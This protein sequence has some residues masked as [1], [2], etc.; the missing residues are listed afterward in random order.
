MT[1]A[2]C[3]KSKPQQSDEM[4]IVTSFYP[5]YIMT[6]NVAG[7]I[8]GIRVENLTPPLTGCLHDYSLT[9]DEM[10]KLE[11]ASVFVTNGAGM[12]SFTYSV[13]RRDPKLKIIDCSAGIYLITENGTENPHVW[14]SVSGAIAEVTNLRNALVKIDPAHAEQYKKNAEQYIM[15]LEELRTQMKSA[16][17]PYRG[18]KIITFHEAFPYFAREFNL[19]IAAVVERDPGSEPSARELAETIALVRGSGIKTIFTEPQYSTAAAKV[20]A[21]ETGAR[22]FTLDPAVSG[23]DDPDAYLITMKK[24]LSTLKEALQ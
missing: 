12:E 6:L 13:A 18:Q 5:I 9:T 20:I 3:G 22:L 16:L 23:D 4:R 8:N 15:K 7:N 17:A 14:V 21:R 2:G 11:T 24:N 19:V 10:K 1:L